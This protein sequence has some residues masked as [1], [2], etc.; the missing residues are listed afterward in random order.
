MLISDAVDFPDA[1]ETIQMFRKDPLTSRLPIGLMAR[2]ENLSRAEA[3]AE[4]DPLL[5]AFPPPHDAKSMSFQLARVLGAAGSSLVGY[6]ERLDQAGRALEH[7]T[8]LGE[9]QEEHAF[10][11]LFR[12][13]EAVQSALSTAALSAK[14]A[15]VL[16]LL[17]TP[18]VQRALVTLASQHARPVAE[19]QAAA[20]AFAQA[21]QRRGLLLTRDEILLQYDRYNRSAGLDADT[22]KV[23]AALLDAI[24]M[25][26]RQRLAKEGL[27]QGAEAA[28]S[29]P[30]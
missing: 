13:Q 22:Q 2:Q 30:N 16:G 26:S 5:V 18:E 29:Q 6:D 9:T 8:R 12:V 19:R 3:M 15:R 21:V 23:L 25:P 10:Y 14:A 7:L 17:G 4:L 28:K 11:D 24:E 27:T 20:E 1:N